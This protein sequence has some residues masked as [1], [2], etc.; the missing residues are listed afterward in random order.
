MLEADRERCMN[1]AV[2]CGNLN[3]LRE[4]LT[5]QAAMPLRG[6]TG[7]LG[8]NDRVDVMVEIVAMAFALLS[9]GIFAAHAYDMVR[10]AGRV[11]RV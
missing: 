7:W 10:N 2:D 9:A 11:R 4:S 6:C 3:V 8:L 5:V 1:V